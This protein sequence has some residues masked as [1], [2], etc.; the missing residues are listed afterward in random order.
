MIHP[1]GNPEANLNSIFHRC[2]P[3]LVSLVW[4]LTKEAIN[5]PL[6]CLQGGYHNF[7]GLVKALLAD[8]GEAWSRCLQNS[9]D[10]ALAKKDKKRLGVIAEFILHHVLIKCFEK[11]NSST[12][13]STDR[14]LL[15]IK[16]IS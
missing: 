13:S 2:H 1:G 7:S 16:T 15:L 11:V 10:V 4:E 3:I 12:T 9:E 5:L 6:G 8:S 14:V